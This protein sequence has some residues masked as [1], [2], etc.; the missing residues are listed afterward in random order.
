MSV[1]I[2]A[3]YYTRAILTVV[4]HFLSLIM[5]YICMYGKTQWISDL[6]VFEISCS[7]FEVLY[8]R[9][10]MFTTPINS[11]IVVKL[12]NTRARDAVL[13]VSADDSTM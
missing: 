3:T 8:Y 6:V 9:G 13:V 1:C 2:C 11:I 7:E 4:V 5:S 10:V 12:M